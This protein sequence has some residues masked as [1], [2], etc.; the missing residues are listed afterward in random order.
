MKTNHIARSHLVLAA[1]ALLILNGCAITQTRQGYQFG[2]DGAV[3]FGTPVSSFKLAD[4]TD[5]T[6]RRSPN[7]EYSLKLQQYFRVLPLPNVQ[8]ARISQ[9]A[10]VGG[11]TSILVETQE[12][13]CA[14]RY[15]LFSIDGGN[16]RNW[17]FGTCNDRPRVFLE[18]GKQLFDFPA[19]R[20]LT[21][22]VLT[23]VGLTRQQL[24]PPPGYAAF[25]R[26]FAN[27]QFQAPQPGMSPYG[28]T[29]Q[30]GGFT[31]NGRVIPPPP[32]AVTADLRKSNRQDDPET[33]SSP[34]ASVPRKPAAQPKPRP[35][36]PPV[37]SDLV[38][39]E[40]VKPTRVVDLTK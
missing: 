38:F 22:Y 28:S 23:E 9:V 10:T 24:D 30:Q 29:A 19:G 37:Q 7:G 40:E 33:H 39:R 14:L 12:K 3:L 25:T 1:L 6:L 5:G 15:S 2:L 16:V 20:S 35:S 8:G 27:E 13:N 31:R 17:V 18:D 21:R 34:P 36:V 32:I 4:G 11:R 26:P